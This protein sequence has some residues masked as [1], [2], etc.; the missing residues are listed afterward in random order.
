MSQKSKNI[1]IGIGEILWDLLPGGK[2]MGG[3]PANFVYT[4][5]SLGGESCI[6]SAVGNDDLGAA[7]YKRLY[8][9][10]LNHTFIQSL[11]EYPT[12]R[13]SVSLD[14][15]GNP[16]Y[17]IHENVA[18]DY[19]QLTHDVKM[20]ATQANAVCFGTLA[21]RSIISRETIQEFLRLTNNNCLH[22]FDVNLRQSYYNS[23][24]VIESLKHSDIVK[25]NDE[26]LPVIAR[27]VSVKGT[28]TQMLL[29][30]LTKF[31]LKLIALTKGRRGSRLVTQ[32]DDSIVR[33][34][35]VKVVDT[36]GAGDAF[37]AALVMGMLAE[38][39]LVEIHNFANRLAAFVCSQKGAMPALP[40]DFKIE[41]FK[42]TE[43]RNA[44][45]EKI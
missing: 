20:L 29:T 25:L 44:I 37:T 24:D 17:T 19:I 39:P 42:L 11:K 26:E 3:A 18:W 35:K 41:F 34:P 38:L 28:E 33:S 40:D 9:F 1:I 30:L 22:V 15:A 4:V 23:E 6:V 36:V 16:A 43:K 32:K 14:D 8:N 7:I 31:D 5:N 45:H 27:M 13:V 21:Q 10:N 12:G 2:L